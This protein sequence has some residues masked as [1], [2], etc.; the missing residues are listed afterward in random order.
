[1]AERLWEI[2]KTMYCDHVGCQVAL[3]SEVVYPAEWLP[4][5]APRILAHRCS[6]GIHCSLYDKPTCVWAGT[7]P[8]Y[9]PFIDDKK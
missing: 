7:N 9:D 4:D 5:Q 1:M 3:E 6:H 8:G 2:V